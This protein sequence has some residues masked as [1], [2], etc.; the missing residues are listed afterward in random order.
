MMNA[1]DAFLHIL[2]V[3]KTGW[4]NNFLVKYEAVH[5]SNTLEE[6]SFSFPLFCK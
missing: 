6:I 5:D 4:G 2:R 3:E 1:S